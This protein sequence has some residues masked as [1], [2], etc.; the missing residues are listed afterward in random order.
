MIDPRYSEKIGIVSQMVKPI[1]YSSHT[2]LL[3]ITIPEA[4]T[5]MRLFRILASSL[6][7]ASSNKHGISPKCSS[8]FI[9][10]GKGK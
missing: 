2:E 6:A 3:S 5:A 1:T 9:Y 4:Q 10:T 7:L 8:G